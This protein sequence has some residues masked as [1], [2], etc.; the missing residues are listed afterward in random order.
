M[1]WTEKLL[2]PVFVWASYTQTIKKQQNPSHIQ[3]HFPCCTCFHFWREFS[4]DLW[5]LVHTSSSSNFF[6]AP[7]CSFVTCNPFNFDKQDGGSL[8][9]LH[10]GRFPHHI[11]RADN[12]SLFN[13]VLSPIKT[14]ADLLPEAWSH[15]I[16]SRPTYLLLSTSGMEEILWSMP[17]STNL[18]AS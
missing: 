6:W 3:P 7:F 8:D 4:R 2:T 17:L 9:Y 13:V 16:W 14:N 5:N 10:I 1:L 15:L 12:S 11:P 18:A